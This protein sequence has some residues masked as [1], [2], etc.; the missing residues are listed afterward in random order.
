MHC[1]RLDHS[2]EVLL[3]H[4]AQYQQQI[5]SSDGSMIQIGTQPA[6]MGIHVHYKKSAEEVKV[7]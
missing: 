6:A 3:I 4:D 2:W 1:G 7:A 5:T